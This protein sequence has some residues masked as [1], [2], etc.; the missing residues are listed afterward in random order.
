MWKPGFAFTEAVPALLRGYHR[1]PCVFSHVHRGTPE[2]PGIVFGLD[3]GG[4]CSGVAYHVH[5]RHRED[6]LRYLRERE[7]TTMVYL[8]RLLP[9]RLATGAR[10]S[11]LTYTVDRTHKQYARKLTL[12]ALVRQVRGARGRSGPNEAYIVETVA[13]LKAMGV[14]DTLL[15]RLADELD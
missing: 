7:Q 11:A 6:V 12:D 14:R 15:E 2:R 1:A 8:E 5:H 10:V 13:K 9:V 4:A 3:R